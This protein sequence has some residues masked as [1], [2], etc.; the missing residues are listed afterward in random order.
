MKKPMVS[1]SQSFSALWAKQPGS[2]LCTSWH[3]PWDREDC[4]NP[5]PPRWGLWNTHH[6]YF[7]VVHLPGGDSETHITTTS[8]LWSTN[9]ETETH[10]QRWVRAYSLHLTDWCQ[11]KCLTCCSWVMSGKVHQGLHVAPVMLG[12]V[13]QG[14]PVPEWCQE[15]CVRAYLLIQSDVRK[16]VSEL[17]CCSRV[18]SGKVCNSQATWSS[19]SSTVTVQVLYTSTPP[20]RNSDTACRTHHSISIKWLF[21][22]I[23][24]LFTPHDETSKYWLQQM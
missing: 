19:F 20:G 23:T 22:C 11:E 12:K 7:K 4:V 1:E 16:G 15:R 9:C 18:M 21:L 2:N 10:Q 17:T 6:H 24:C 13:C 8:S 5:Q 14:L 3:S